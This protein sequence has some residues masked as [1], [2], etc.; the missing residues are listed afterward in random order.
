MARSISAR[1][2]LQAATA[3]LVLTLCSLVAAPAQAATAYISDELTVPMRSGASNGHRILRI[4]PAGARLDVRE[5]D[6]EAGY[7]R[8]ATQDGTEGWVPLQYLKDQPIARDRLEAATAEVQRLTQTVTELRGRLETVQGVRQEAE[9][10]NSSLVDDVTRLEQELAEVR[11]V[12]ATAIETA[13]ANQRLTD[14][15]ARLREELN[16]LVEERDRLAANSQERWLMIGGGLVLLGLFLGMILK[17]RPR[18]SA[19]S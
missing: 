7:A 15:N 17:A 4:L 18:R 6:T 16:Q 19:W 3:S 12:S 9:E 2:A 5:R 10:T 11:R 14:L 13:S 8:V 1:R